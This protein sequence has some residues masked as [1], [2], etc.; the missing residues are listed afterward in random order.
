MGLATN[1]HAI[2]NVL[3]RPAPLLRTHPTASG[4]AAA[5]FVPSDRR[6]RSRTGQLVLACR[7]LAAAA[8]ADAARGR[9]AP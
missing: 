8:A 2:H 1:L 9:P 3:E 4:V 6:G 5:Q 7:L